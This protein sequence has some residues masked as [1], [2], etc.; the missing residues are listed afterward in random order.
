[1]DEIKNKM[2]KLKNENERTK[3]GSFL[4]A[5]YLEKLNNLEY[6]KYHALVSAFEVPVYNSY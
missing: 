4:P 2:K 5:N 1:M 3:C 6:E